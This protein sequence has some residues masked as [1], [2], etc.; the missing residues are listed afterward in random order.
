MKVF[1]LLILL[2]YM[3]HAA[4]GG[5]SSEPWPDV[6]DACYQMDKTCEI[7]KL[8]IQT[9][10]GLEPSNDLMLKFLGMCIYTSI[11]FFKVYS[12]FL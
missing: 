8:I 9:T 4:P 12:T 11:V 7:R 2:A 3:A 10:L 1:G 5:G 6:D